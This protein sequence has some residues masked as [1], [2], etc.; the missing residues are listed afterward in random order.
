MTT[1][2]EAQIINHSETQY[3][4]VS[5]DDVKLRCRSTGVPQPTHSW[6]KQR[7]VHVAL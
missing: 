4:V 5:G 2:K 7:L 6:Y 1:V 3:R